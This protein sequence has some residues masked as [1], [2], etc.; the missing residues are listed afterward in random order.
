MVQLDGYDFDLERFMS[1]D[2]FNRMA[3]FC[4][5]KE[6]PFLVLD[7]EKVGEKYDE[8]T[9]AF[10]FSK[11]YYAIKANPHEEVLKLLAGKG[12]C[13]DVASTYEL[14][15]IMNLGVGPERLSYGNTIKKSKDIAYAFQKG[16]RLFATDSEDDL[17]KIAI[18]A[19]GS[20][21]FFRLLTDGS[22]ADWPLSRKFG[23]HQDVI[24]KLIE[25]ASKLD[26][27][28]YGI[29]FHVGSQQRDIG[30]WDNAISACRYVFD[31]AKEMGIN[32]KMINMGGGFPASY[33]DPNLDFEVYRTEISRFLQEDF[34][35]EFPEILIEPG[36]SMVGDAGILVSEVVLVSQ[37][38]EYNQY[39]WVYL[40]VGKFGGLIET[41]DEA[42]KY[43]IFINKEGNAMEAILAGP[44]CDSMDILYEDFKYTIP[45][46]TE[47]GDRVYFF[48]AGAYTTSYSSINFNGFPPL[49]TYIL[50]SGRGNSG[51][52]RSFNTGSLFD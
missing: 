48:T 33:Q 41:L 28:P 19:P 10:P 16:V 39:V 1:R 13:F 36:R 51:K 38:A 50:P 5:K 35:D 31:W 6:T 3:A 7:L 27:E 32:L 15:Q 20:K 8:L 25:M 44:T 26:V 37:K 9:D 22:G 18:N 24:I 30:Q 45:D 34:G 2:N 4:S 14:D 49:K 29:S 43:P 17:R 46:T 12:S 40:D 21:V 42:I 52:K 47:E 23:A 11:I